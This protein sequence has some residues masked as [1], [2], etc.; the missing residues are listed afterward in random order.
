MN[1]SNYIIRVNN[2]SVCLLFFLILLHNW[3][4]RLD[5]FL[6]HLTFSITI[7]IRIIKLR[8]IL[9]VLKFRIFICNFWFLFC[10]R[11]SRCL[12][13]IYIY[14]INRILFILLSLFAAAAINPS[15]NSCYCGY[16]QSGYC[17]SSS[18]VSIFFL[19]FA[20]HFSFYYIYI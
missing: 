20:L 18:I 13:T 5:L 3:F 14:F 6:I 1:Y 17:Y 19:I 11:S 9:W 10:S 4:L 8:V 2:F 16:C 12:I 7:K 15:S